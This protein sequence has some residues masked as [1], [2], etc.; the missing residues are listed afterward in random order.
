M[1]ITIFTLFPEM[2]EPFF[3]LSIMKRAV[4]K[5]LVSYEIVN[6]RDFAD[7]VHKKADDIPYGGGAGMVLM[8]DPISKALEEYGAKGK[9]VVFPTPSGKPFTE[10]YAMDL[11]SESELFFICGHY[12]GLDQRVIDEYVTDEITI[13]DYVLSSGETASVVIIDALYRLIDGVISNE[14]LEDESFSSNLLE[15]PQYTRPAR[16]CTKSVPDVLLTGHHGHITQW[17][18]DKRLEKTMLNRPDLLS[19][20]SL[21]IEERE[22]L[23][24]ILDSE[25][26]RNSQRWMLSEL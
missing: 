1:K 6:F 14:S 3:T 19:N 15:Y 2:V 24:K 16:Y 10:R 22:R 7:G 18:C 12:E 21:S 5:A 26:K 4:E 23:L 8:P 9:R 20:A 25:D 17:R 13:G 11:S